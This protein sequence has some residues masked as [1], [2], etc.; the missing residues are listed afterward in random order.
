MHKTLAIVPILSLAFTLSACEEVVECTDLAAAS[1][2]IQI[3]DVDGNPM[4]PTSVTYTVDGGA[5]QEAECVNEPCTEWV[6]GWE[7]E[8]DFEITVSYE[9]VDPEDEL[10]SWSDSVTESVSVGLTEDECHVDGEVLEVTLD[11]EYA[12]AD[13]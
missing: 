8:G 11:P 1:V 3:V 6:A 12:C 5:E 9:E 7:V 2:N 10:C 4:V 13:S